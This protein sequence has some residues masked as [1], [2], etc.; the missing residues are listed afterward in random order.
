[1]L[2]LQE[3]D[4]EPYKDLLLA[5]C[6]RNTTY[7]PQSEGNKTRYL[8]ELIQLTQDQAFYRDAILAAMRAL[9][10]PP[11]DEFDELYWDTNQLFEFGVF[12]AQQ[13]DDAFHRATYDLFVRR[14]T[15]N[16]EF[17][18]NNLIELDGFAGFLFVA[19]HL[20]SLPELFTPTLNTWYIDSVEERFSAEVIRQ[21]I[22][23]EVDD[24]GLKA[25]ISYPRE[26]Q[27]ARTRK[28]ACATA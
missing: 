21:Y 2:F 8:F 3:H 28:H 16:C 24:P 14:A 22:E 5:H 11:E 20:Y 25:Y 13:G 18:A 6:L 10:A 23:R 26:R 27:Q 15:T 7:D 19:K 17:G 9:P 4:A 1:M 12:F